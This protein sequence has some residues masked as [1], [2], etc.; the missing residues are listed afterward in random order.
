MISFAGATRTAPENIRS[1]LIKQCN[2][3]KD[4]TLCNFFNCGVKKCVGLAFPVIKLFMESEFCL[5]PDGDSPTRKSVFDS[6]I[7][8]CIP[9]VFDP[10]T[11]HYQYPWHLPEDY[12]KYCVFIEQDEV[13]MSEVN[14]VE[15][16][17][18]I[19]VKER[20]EM[21]KYIIDELMPKLSYANAN[22]KLKI[23]EDA[24]TIAV[25]N[26]V[27]MAIQRLNSSVGI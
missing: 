12:R 4:P 1:I 16:L 19:T 22:A 9:V 24:F 20:Q 27:Q 17:R 23:F 26:A 11:A 18:K 13:K 3:V 21:R 25:N 10:F 14:V 6:L 7:A 8:G 5:Q 2:S 15:K